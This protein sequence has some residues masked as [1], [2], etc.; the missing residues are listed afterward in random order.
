VASASASTS[1]VE[2]RLATC[3]ADHAT[4]GHLGP[5]HS[6][7]MANQTPRPRLQGRRHRQ[8]VAR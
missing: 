6:C 1:L 8:A 4:V 7:L 5:C 2:A 3:H